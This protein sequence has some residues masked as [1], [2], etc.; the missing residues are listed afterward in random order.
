MDSDIAITL[1]AGV[2]LKNQDKCDPVLFNRR[3][4][5]LYWSAFYVPMTRFILRAQDGILEPGLGIFLCG[6]IW[7]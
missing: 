3:F 2:G 1:T 7:S 5:L 6:Q 4:V